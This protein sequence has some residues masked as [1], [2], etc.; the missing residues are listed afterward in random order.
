[1]FC[2][3]ENIRHEFVPIRGSQL[4]VYTRLASTWYQQP[5]IEE[6]TPPIVGDSEIVSSTGLQLLN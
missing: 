1:M 4:D 3:G 2:A 6:I 5:M